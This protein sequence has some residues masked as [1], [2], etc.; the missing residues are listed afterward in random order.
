MRS[1]VKV[2]YIA[3]NKEAEHFHFHLST[4]LCTFIRLS[5]RQKKYAVAGQQFDKMIDLARRRYGED[6]IELIDMYQE[7]GRVSFF[8]FL[9][10]FQ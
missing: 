6:A 7:N 1:H 8:S 3:L 2:F 10:L 5:W 4:Y 9:F